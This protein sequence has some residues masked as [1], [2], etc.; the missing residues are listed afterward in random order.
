[1][2]LNQIPPLPPS[3]T[4]RPMPVE[5]QPQ[6][7]FGDAGTLL[8]ACHYGTP[9]RAPMYR[10]GAPRRRAAASFGVGVVAPTDS[11]QPTAPSTS[12]VSAAHPVVLPPRDV[13][14]SR[15]RSGPLLDEDVRCPGAD[16]HASSSTSNP[17]L[18]RD[19]IRSRLSVSRSTSASVTASMTASG[20]AAR[21]T[22]AS[23]PPPR[24]S[25]S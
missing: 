12:C 14:R 10:S 5:K 1:M 20:S 18:W 13:I 3:R 19:A 23:I 9:A 25:R 8:A 2:T 22:A 16:I 4:A 17:I 7:A 6:P 21:N 24:C 11:G 15:R